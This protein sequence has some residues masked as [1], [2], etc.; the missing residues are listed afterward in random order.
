MPVV[1][2]TLLCFA[3]GCLLA[4]CR[5]SSPPPPTS[6]RT[7]DHGAWLEGYTEEDLLRFA[8]QHAPPGTAIGQATEELTNRGFVCTF[9]PSGEGCREMYCSLDRKVDLFV[10]M[11]Y[12]IRADIE[13]GRIRS[14]K[15]EILAM[16]P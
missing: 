9:F 6:G 4:G 2:G 3:A 12:I 16:G 5:L 1:R 8:N 14:W 7:V 13:D 11:I 10:T 15:S